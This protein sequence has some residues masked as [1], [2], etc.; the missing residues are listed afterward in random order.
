MAYGVYDVTRGLG[1]SGVSRREV[2]LPFLVELLRD[3]RGA[4]KGIPA[5]DPPIN[6]P[7]LASVVKETKCITFKINNFLPLI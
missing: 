4:N 6:N 7:V 2:S 3:V 1:N 5:Q